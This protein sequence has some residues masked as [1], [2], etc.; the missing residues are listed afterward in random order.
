MWDESQHPRGQ[1]DNAGKWVEKGQQV[2]GSS[3]ETG[4]SQSGKHATLE[5]YK[6]KKD[7]ASRFGDQAGKTYEDHVEHLER[8][9]TSLGK[10]QNRQESSKAKSLSRFAMQASDNIGYGKTGTDFTADIEHRIAAKEH[11]AT[12]AMYR[13]YV[14]R[15]IEEGELASAEIGL[16]A[17]E[18]HELLASYHRKAA[19]SHYRAHA[20]TIGIVKQIKD[21]PS[22]KPK[23]LT[24]QMQES[25][26]RS[27]HQKMQQQQNYEDDEKPLW[28]E[29]HESWQKSRIVP[30]YIQMHSHY[31]SSSALLAAASEVDGNPTDE[32]KKAGNYRKGHFVW[33]GLPITIETAKGQF[34]RGIGDDGKLWKTKMVAHYGYIKRTESEADGDHIDVFIGPDLNSEVVFVINQK[35]QSG[36]FD[37]HKCM[38]ACIS[39]DQAKN[40]YLSNYEA[41]WKGLGSITA[42]TIGQFKEWIVDGDTSKELGPDSGIDAWWLYHASTAK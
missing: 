27:Q 15:S 16:D 6:I 34:R 33:K 19:L 32:Q 2:K 24:L 7:A 23:D 1:P 37:E 22:D 28:Q 11:A 10:I 41:N 14:K 39:A 8:I 30:L 40:L 42:M 25:Y 21:H 18:V 35:K 3:K 36:E 17:A 20:Y 4:K 29:M 31:E 9:R 12:A 5:S 38:L 26:L 13:D